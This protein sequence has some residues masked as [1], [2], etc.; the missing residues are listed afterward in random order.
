MSN[1]YNKYFF[2][3]AAEIS[4]GNEVLVPGNNEL[5]PVKVI[6]VSTA[7]VQGNSHY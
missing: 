5:I 1:I 3:Y 7:N 6:N 4:I 2:R